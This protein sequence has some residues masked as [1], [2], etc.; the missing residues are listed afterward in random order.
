VP[1]RPDALETLT[2]ALE[3]LRRI[4]RKRKV[5]ASEL[6]KQLG[7]AGLARDLRTIQR[8]LE[9]LSEHFEI[10]RD[11]R[12]KP[13]G[14]R[15]K[16]RAEGFSLPSLGPQE[17]LILLLAE[18]HLRHLLPQS[19]IKSM[20]G[21]FAQAQSNLGPLS[22]AR[23]E[24][25]WLRK[26][27]VVSTTQPLLPPKIRPGVFEEVSQALFSNLWLTVE[28]RNAAGART[29]SDVM[30]LGLAQ[31]GPRLYLV[32]RFQG[33]DN[34]RILALHRIESA[35]TT[36]LSFDRPKGFDLEAYDAEGKFGFGEGKH[37]RLSFR[38]DKGAGLHLLESPLSE[39]QAVREVED[40]YEITATVVDTA[41]LGW[42][43]N[44]FGDLVWD[45]RRRPIRA[46]AASGKG[47]GL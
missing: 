19:L 2:L 24:R 45:V 38:I 25:E 4:P 27:R 22:S 3:L 36:T 7:A 31:Q 15:W 5:T 32:C 30:P 16:E 18:Q 47:A 11:D 26:V 29:R 20:A 37:I 17:S 21:F 33:F 34:E 9:A 28:Y 40:G 6:H 12:S 42:W 35:R 44:G 46:K 23:R 1:R 8:Q 14:Y 10:E 39:D 13:Y 41:M 43:L